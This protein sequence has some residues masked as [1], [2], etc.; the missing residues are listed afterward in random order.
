M[1]VIESKD[2]APS[3]CNDFKCWRFGFKETEEEEIPM[4]EPG[5]RVWGAVQEY[6]PDPVYARILPGDGAEEGKVKV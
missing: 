6:E 2:D 3:I 1:R 5:A 4:L